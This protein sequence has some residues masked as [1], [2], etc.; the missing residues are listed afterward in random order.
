MVGGL[1]EASGYIEAIS[2]Q[3]GGEVVEAV[4][5]TAWIMIEL[6]RRNEHDRC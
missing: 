2:G 4:M 1:A 3:E 5:K 6:I